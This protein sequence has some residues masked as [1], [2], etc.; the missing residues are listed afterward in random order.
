MSIKTIIPISEARKRI[1]QLAKEV[2]R[3]S[4]FYTLTDKG[5][6]KAVI[7]SAQ[8][9][10][11]WQETIEIMNI[12][13]NWEKDIQAAEEDYKKGRTISLEKLLAK[14]GFVLQKKKSK[15]HV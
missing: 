9:F 13:P 3:P 5:T 1:F 15:K 7:I 8:D 4:V 11:S 14:E 12:F 2:Q 10:E 6:P